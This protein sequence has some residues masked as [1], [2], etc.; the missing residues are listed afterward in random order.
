MFR[1]KTGAKHYWSWHCCQSAARSV[2]SQAVFPRPCFPA[3]GILG[4]TL[5]DT[6]QKS[7][8]VGEDGCRHVVRIAACRRVLLPTAALGDGLDSAALP[9][10]PA[11][12]DPET[13]PS[14]W[15][16]VL[17][18]FKLKWLPL[19]Q[20][21]PAFSQDVKQWWAEGAE[22]INEELDLVSFLKAINYEECWSSF[23][24][25]S[26]KCTSSQRERTQSRAYE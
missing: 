22:G 6:F 26:P 14:F 11:P 15:G 17:L 4:G 2:V 5:T 24:H 23:F 9:V 25:T 3:L 19:G 1:R 21:L 10:L 20:L 7:V 13:R 18:V 12:W 8:F 16:Q